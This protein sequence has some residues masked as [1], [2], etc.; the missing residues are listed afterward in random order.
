[1]KVK[2]RKKKNYIYQRVYLYLKNL[3]QASTCKNTQKINILSR[4]NVPIMLA[5]Q[6]HK[7]SHSNFSSLFLCCVLH[8]KIVVTVVPS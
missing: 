3:F 8:F 4:L 1:M 2:S 7:S 5:K 6:F